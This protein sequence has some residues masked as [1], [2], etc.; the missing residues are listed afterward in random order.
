MSITLHHHLISQRS[1]PVPPA[2]SEPDFARVRRQIT[3]DSRP[4]LF[5]KHTLF[6]SKQQN[7]AQ[8]PPQ[9]PEQAEPAVRL[10]HADHEFPP[11][12]PLLLLSLLLMSAGA[13]RPLPTAVS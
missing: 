6:A 9:S 11:A 7:H 1:T 8:R 12:A 13:G 2:P 5:S 10:R 4:D 3:L